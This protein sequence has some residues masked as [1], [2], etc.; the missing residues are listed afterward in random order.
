MEYQDINVE[1][2][3]LD[4]KRLY[5]PVTFDLLKAKIKAV[6]GIVEKYITFEFSHFLSPQSIYLSAR[7]LNETYKR[8]YGGR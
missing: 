4:V 7:S 3:E 2:F 1:T 6:E 5:Y 8:Y